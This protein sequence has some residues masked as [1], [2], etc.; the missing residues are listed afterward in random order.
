MN[1]FKWAGGIAGER[2]L[3]S[4]ELLLDYVRFV[5]SY[6]VRNGKPTSSVPLVVHPFLIGQIPAGAASVPGRPF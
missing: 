1:Q 2:E 5:K 6:F 4:V 3:T